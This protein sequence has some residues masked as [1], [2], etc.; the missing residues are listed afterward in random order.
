MKLASGI[1][2]KLDVR[3]ISAIAVLLFGFFPLLGWATDTAAL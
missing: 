3:G 1:A 2:G